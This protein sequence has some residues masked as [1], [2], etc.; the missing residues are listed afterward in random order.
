MNLFKHS[1]VE[2]TYVVAE[3]HAQAKG[4][5]CGLYGDDCWEDG[6]AECFSTMPLD[7]KLTIDEE[8]GLGYRKV[9]KTVFEWISEGPG[10]VASTC[11]F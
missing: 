10:I 9:T 4:F 8:E 11:G 7:D 6:G 1:S 5:I 2:T 3:D